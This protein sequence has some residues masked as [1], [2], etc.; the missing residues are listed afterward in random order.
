M[1]KTWKISAMKR[2]LLISHISINMLLSN[3]L[4][5]LWKMSCQVTMRNELFISNR[6]TPNYVKQVMIKLF[7][8]FVPGSKGFGLAAFISDL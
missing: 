3:A 6:N 2:G 5:L 8:I 1:T 7:Y 4:F